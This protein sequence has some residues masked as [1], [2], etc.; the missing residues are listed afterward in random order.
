MNHHV[1]VID[2]NHKISIE[3]PGLD[4]G[5]CRMYQTCAICYEGPYYVNRRNTVEEAGSMI[6]HQLEH[7]VIDGEICAETDECLIQYMDTERA[8]HEFL[9]VNPATGI[10]R[11]GR[12]ECTFVH[13]HF[14]IEF[15]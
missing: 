8:V 15:C 4:V 3:C 9:G 5:S 11:P 1:I 2:E 12:Y 13:G 14:G 6:L 10:L 7:I